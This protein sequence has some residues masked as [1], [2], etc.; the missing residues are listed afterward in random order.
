MPQ[1]M[2]APASVKLEA[3]AMMEMVRKI[4]GIFVITQ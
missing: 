3:K 4:L 1:P 2:L